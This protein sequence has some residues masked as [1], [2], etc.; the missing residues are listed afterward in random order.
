[1]ES[2]SL[3]TKLLEREWLL[4][5]IYLILL[6]LLFILFP[7]REDLTVI[8]LISLGFLLFFAWWG[9]VEFTPPIILS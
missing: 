6:L 1:M 3:L 4:V 7:L 8:L 9:R 5:Y 2:F